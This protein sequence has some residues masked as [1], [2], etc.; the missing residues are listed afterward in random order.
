MELNNWKEIGAFGCDLY[1]AN[2]QITA[3][4][5][6]IFQIAGNYVSRPQRVEGWD[7]RRPAAQTIHKKFYPRPELCRNQKLART[8]SHKRFGSCRCRSNCSIVLAMQPTP[9]GW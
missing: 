4:D 6:R 8:L 1:P 2:F 3:D 9:S 7:L 5:L